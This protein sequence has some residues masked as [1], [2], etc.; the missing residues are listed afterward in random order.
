MRPSRPQFI[1]PIRYTSMH[2]KYVAPWNLSTGTI[3]SSYVSGIWVPDL[4]ARFFPLRPA[5]VGGRLIFSRRGQTPPDLR[6]SRPITGPLSPRHRPFVFQISFALL[7]DHRYA[8]FVP[9]QFRLDMP[10]RNFWYIS[11]FFFLILR[12][13][14]CGWNYGWWVLWRFVKKKGLISLSNCEKWLPIF[15]RTIFRNKSRP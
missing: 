5:T 2:L 4:A 12:I 1:R 14:P 7:L 13:V 8:P 11:L 3:T 6:P 10:F 9:Q 15:V